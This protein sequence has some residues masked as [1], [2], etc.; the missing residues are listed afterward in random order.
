[1]SMGLDLPGPEFIGHVVDR[2][3]SICNLINH[4]NNLQLHPLK[5]LNPSLR[6]RD[7]QKR[8]KDITNLRNWLTMDEDKGGFVVLMVFVVKLRRSVEEIFSSNFTKISP[9]LSIKRLACMWH[10]PFLS[11][12]K[13]FRMCNVLSITMENCS[14]TTETLLVV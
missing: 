10:T 7:H 5:I 9:V 13:H 14:T 3:P 4:F 11:I 1:M 12:C 6:H 2:V 8:C